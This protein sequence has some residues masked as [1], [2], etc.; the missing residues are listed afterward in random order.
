MLFETIFNCFFFFRNLKLKPQI[1]TGGTDSRYIRQLGLPAIGFSPMNNTP[2]LLHDND[3]YIAVDT[4]VKGIEIY[5]KIITE[6]ANV[7]DRT[8]WLKTAV[9]WKTKFVYNDVKK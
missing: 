1:F 9:P 3:E 4:F 5:R 2:I 6:V 8:G 7:E